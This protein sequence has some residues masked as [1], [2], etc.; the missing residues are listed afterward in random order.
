MS[1]KP[2]RKGDRIVIG[3]GHPWHGHSGDITDGDPDGPLQMLLVELDNGQRCYA[4][5]AELYHV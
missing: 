4:S 1:D 5:P 2:F 3:K